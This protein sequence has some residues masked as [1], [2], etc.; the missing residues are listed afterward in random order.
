MAM[1][2]RFRS[3]VPRVAK[4]LMSDSLS[5]HRSTVQRSLL[6]SNFTDPQQSRNFSSASPSK[7]P[8]IKVPVAMFG[9]SGNYASALFIAAAKAKAL[10]KV[11]SE[12]ID[13]VAATEKSPTFS[14]FMKDLAVPADTRVKAVT[15]ICDQAKFSEVTKNFLI[16]LADNG[17]LRH[18]DTIAKRFSDLTMAHRGEIKAIVTT[19]I[20]LPAEEEKE[21]KDTLQEILGKG[22][23]VNLEQKIDP[24]ILGGI[25]VEFGQKV[26]DASIKT[27]AKQM[28]RFLRNPVNFDV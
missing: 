5:T 21:L 22:K 11:E 6:C 18:V 14:Q 20:P 17:R 26:F 27:R 25:V 24:S 12:L 3:T 13:L 28:E 7:E 10:D 23:K 19:V 9:G 8:K 4:S 1:A 15:E 16:L 2:G